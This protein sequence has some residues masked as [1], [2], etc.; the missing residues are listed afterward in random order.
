MLF[1][2]T[3]VESLGAVCGPARAEAQADAT[4]D[5]PRRRR[6]HTNARVAAELRRL[7]QRVPE[8]GDEQEVR[9]LVDLHLWIELVLRRDVFQVHDA[10]YWLSH[11]K[12]ETSKMKLKTYGKEVQQ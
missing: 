11:G 12:L 1:E 6:V 10:Y 7:R 3:R 8:L 5:I 2:E 9:D 4:I